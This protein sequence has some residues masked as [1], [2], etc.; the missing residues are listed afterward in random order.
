MCLSVYLG[1]N[2]P[3]LV[4]D[5]VRLGCLGIEGASWKPP[6]LENRKH[7][8]FLGRKG[9]G[10]E[11]ECSC[12][13]QEY[14]TWTETEAKVEMDD[15]YPDNGPCPFITLSKL[16][17]TALKTSTSCAI[18]CDDSNGL[19]QKCEKS[20]Y[21]DLFLTPSMIKRGNLIFSGHDVPYRHYTVISDSI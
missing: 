4:S 9:E 13:L 8:Y 12:L 11:L 19:E 7:V 6:T 16:C 20:D 14:V 2:E 18:A 3:I 15:L 21:H 10:K 5:I 17:E 1:V